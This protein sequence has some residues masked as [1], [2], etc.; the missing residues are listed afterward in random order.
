M[1]TNS[2]QLRAKDQLTLDNLRERWHGINE[3]ILD[4]GLKK[5]EFLEATT[6]NPNPTSIR[7]NLVS[8]SNF[9]PI[10]SFRKRSPHYMSLLWLSLGFSDLCRL[11][12]STDWYNSS[13]ETVPW[14]HSCSMTL[15]NAAGGKLAVDWAEIV[16]AS[17]LI[18]FGWAAE[19]NSYL[20]WPFQQDCVSIFNS[21]KLIVWVWVKELWTRRNDDHFW[22]AWFCLD[23]RLLCR[24]LQRWLHCPDLPRPR[25]ASS[26][27][28]TRW[29]RPSTTRTW[30]SPRWRRLSTKTNRP[31]GLQ[32]SLR[33]LLPRIR[34]W[35]PTAIRCL[36][37]PTQ[38]GFLTG[39]YLS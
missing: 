6:E 21:T 13:F 25:T 22:H 23:F 26:S 8:H 3:S 10:L 18:F 4:S 2:F 29:P 31:L 39:S 36:T 30:T 28:R 19:Q 9:I 20:T 1:K 35:S 17:K 33:Q 24:K 32:L 7:S 5:P 15:L 34:W 12:P 11:E 16:T 14:C 27:F 37:R 38:N